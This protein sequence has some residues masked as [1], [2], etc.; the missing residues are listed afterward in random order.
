M[1]ASAASLR[2]LTLGK[3]ELGAKGG[4]GFACP[5][6]ILNMIFFTTSLDIFPP[7]L[8]LPYRGCIL[9]LPGCNCRVPVCVACCVFGCGFAQLACASSS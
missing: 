8:V 7:L 6:G 2:S 5:A 9:F 3:V 1:L 4:A